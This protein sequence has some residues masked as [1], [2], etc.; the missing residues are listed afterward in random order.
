MDGIAVAS[1][2]LAMRALWHTAKKIHNIIKVTKQ[3]QT[4]FSEEIMQKSH[5]KTTSKLRTADICTYYHS[6]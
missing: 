5:K 4:D 6:P 2:A 1:T 3:K